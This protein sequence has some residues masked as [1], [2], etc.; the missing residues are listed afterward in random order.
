[1]K[2]KHLRC[3]FVFVGGLLLTSLLTGCSGT[4]RESIRKQMMVALS[5]VPDTLAT[6]KG[7]ESADSARPKLNELHDRLKA[8]QQK[9]D[10]LGASSPAETEA[11]AKKFAPESKKITE[12]MVEQQKRIEKLAP[13]R[14]TLELEMA[15]HAMIMVDNYLVGRGVFEGKF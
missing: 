11:L 5:E 15:D 2:G 1:M 13:G 6:I 7:I 9:Y 3:N 10:E 12:K 8:L 14:I 4:G